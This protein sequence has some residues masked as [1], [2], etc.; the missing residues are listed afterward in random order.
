MECG[1]MNDGGWLMNKQLREWLFCVFVATWAPPVSGQDVDV[2]TG[3]SLYVPLALS[4][5]LTHRDGAIVEAL[6][7]AEGLNAFD[8]ILLVVPQERPDAWKHPL[9]LHAF[10]ICRDRNVA[11]IWCRNLWRARGTPAE[12]AAARFAH[13]APA[14]YAAAIAQLKAE[15]A[16]L[17]AVGTCL[18][19]EPY[20]NAPQ[21]T[22]LKGVALSVWQQWRMR[23]AI[24]QATEVAGR[25]D[26]MRPTSSGQTHGYQWP[27]TH[28]GTYRLESITYKAGPDTNWQPRQARP[29]PNYEWRIDMW[30]SHVGPDALSIGEAKAFELDVIQKT[31]PACRGQ[32]IYIPSNQFADTLRRW[33]EVEPEP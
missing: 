29:P 14:H 18:D 11:V 2:V 31:H 20:A 23:S 24:R 9:V 7:T 17:G 22:L 3:K 33:H 12:L 15:A 16:A 28:L 1:V 27:L 26:L 19:G 32:W 6:R 8:R 5:E 4:D 30:G 21:K 25:V 13:Y 10:E